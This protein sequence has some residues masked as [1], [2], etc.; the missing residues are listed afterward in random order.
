MNDEDAV[1]EQP[2]DEIGMVP[3][4]GDAGDRQEEGR[5]HALLEIA[6]ALNASLSLDSA[7]ARVLELAASAIDADA[8]SLFVK[9]SEEH[10]EELAV[11]FAR[12]GGVLKEGMVSVPLGL[13][14]YVLATGESV[15]VDDVSAEPRFAGKLDSKFGTRTH[16]ILAVPMSREDRLA[17]LLEAIRERRDP[18]TEQD[19]EF[20]EAVAHELAVAVENAR[21][22]ER[23][24]WDLNA[25][26]MLLNAARKVASSLQVVEVL[27]HL[28]DSLSELVP[29]DAGGIY[30]LQEDGVQL[31]RIEHRGYP[32]NTERLLRDRPGKG[33]TGWVA[34]N[35][36]GIIVDYVKSDPRYIEARPETQSEI[37]APIVHAD[38]V[39]GVITLES[40]R[41][42]AF[43]ERQLD[44]LETI[45][46]Q[47]ASAIT[48]ARYFHAQI[49]RTRLDH[50][51]AMSRE[52]QRALFPAQPFR[53]EHVEATGINV[54]SSAVGGDY[55][56]YFAECSRHIGI[57]L[58]DVSGHGLSASLLTTAV[59]TGVRLSSG[60]CPEPA[61]LAW[62][63][64]QLLYESTP[65][66]HFVAA[67]LGMLERKTG[68]LRYCNA[69]HAPPLWI[70]N[71][72]HSLLRGGG[73]ILGAF[74]DSLYEQVD[75]QLTDGDLLV[76]YTDGLTEMAN[77]EGEQFGLDRLARAVSENRDKSLDGIIQSVREAGH[78]HHGGGARDDD[79]TLMLLRWTG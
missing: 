50:E 30:L 41:P 73:L 67:V 78:A 48:N 38:K 70:T 51:I 64:N 32:P 14:G 65:A 36:K 66:N 62:Q 72:G 55:Y 57:A 25:R 52:I 24:R 44:L 76:F 26:E 77:S 39:M 59:R 6:R 47:V 79:I 16:S 69:G 20:L 17:G 4:R 28:L 75:I 5:E 35:R 54:P 46:G 15:R 18:F 3:A 31:R 34:R 56:D 13:S 22:I 40:D 8:V 19:L 27:K 23:M 68:V 7:L 9:E 29:Y 10:E 53:D 12:P 43:N 42:C 49:E 74:P 21:L 58:A 1:V 61:S 63:L 11:S 45:G 60:I 37:A 71:G 2:P 33:I